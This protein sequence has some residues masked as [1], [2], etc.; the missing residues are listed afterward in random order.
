MKNV[1]RTAVALIIIALCGFVF[2]LNVLQQHYPTNRA[3]LVYSTIESAVDIAF[4]TTLGQNFIVGFSGPILTK[5][6]IKILHSIKPGGVVLYRRNFDSF[7]QFKALIQQLQS[8]SIKDSGFPYFI[9]ID[10]E[11]NGASR[12]DLLKDVFTLGTPNWKLIDSGIAGLAEL[13]INVEL[14]PVADFPFNDDTFIKKRVPTKNIEDLES[15]N[16]SFIRM[17]NDNHIFATLKHFPGAGVFKADPHTSIPS[18]SV[19]EATLNQSLS[20]FQS[21]IDSG[22]QFVMTNH[23]IYTNI[24]SNNPASLSKTIITKLLKEKLGFKGIIITDDIEDMLSPV[25]NIKP[26]DAGLRALL[27]GN[28]MIM[29]SQNLNETYKTFGSI[30]E[31]IIKNQNLKNIVNENYQKIITL[32]TKIE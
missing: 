14:A 26:A 29:Y 23:A 2:Y 8:I 25:W 21:G 6:D 12:L 28:T 24:D 7:K 4:N 30:K 10:E 3:D 19:D 1:L 18:G 32:K 16:A 5:Q 11:P 31:Q 27:A 20:I 13:G 22:A 17:L 9:M 15:F